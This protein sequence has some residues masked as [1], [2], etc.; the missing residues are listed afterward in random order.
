MG[1]PRTSTFVGISLDGFLARPDGSLDW[2][3]PFEGTEH[4]YTAF[5][6]MIDTLVIGRGTY[7][8]VLGML[9]SGLPWPYQ[10]KRCV[11]M[12]HRPIEGRHGESAFAGEPR[13]LLE[14][15]SGQGA[16]QVYVDG[17]V[18]IRS[19][20]A[21][22]LLDEITVSVVPV[23]I[24]VGIPLFGGVA[25]ESGLVLEKATSFENGIAQLRYR[26]QSAA[27]RS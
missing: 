7:D 12:T 22:G 26:V 8:F 21:S 6:A 23:L 25:L 9:R 3:K 27:S 24:G 10:G 4:G 18:V 17:G 13:A 11:V 2:L 15:L 14:V 19:F 20:L 16:R 1:R 5:I